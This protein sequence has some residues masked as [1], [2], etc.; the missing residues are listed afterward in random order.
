M[1]GYHQRRLPDHSDLLAG[2]KP[3]SE[4]GFRSDALQIWYNNTDSPWR[5]P[6]AHMHTDSDECFVVLR[7]ELVVEVDGERFTVGPREFCCFP[8]G[9][10]H[11]VIEAHP[12]VETLMIRTPSIE[13]KH[14]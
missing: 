14:Y 4:V 11:A 7:G 6:G 9:L 10:Y 13:D 5:D 2:R 3:P 1:S 12:P 8:R